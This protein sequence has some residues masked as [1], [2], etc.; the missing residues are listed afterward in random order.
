MNVTYAPS[1]GRPAPT[2]DFVNMVRGELFKISRNTGIWVT[3]GILTV[4]FLTFQAGSI[5]QV[6]ALSTVSNTFSSNAT[7]NGNPFQVN[8]A[9]YLLQTV[10]GTVN[11]WV[12]IYLMAVAVIVVALEYQQGTIRVLL[13]RGVGRMRLLSAKVSAVILYGLTALLLALALTVGEV[14]SMFNLSNHGD[15]IANL[16]DYFWSD[17]ATYVLT[18]L[19]GMLATISLAATFAVL[20]RSLAFGL[21]FTLPYFL[22]ENIVG[23]IM[24]GIGI[25]TQS[26]WLY[27][28]TQFFL[29]VNINNIPSKLLSGHSTI[30]SL[31]VNN[32]TTNNP[33]ILIHDAS[34]S[35]IVVV[36]YIVGLGAIA[37]TV[38][39]YRDVQN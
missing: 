10:L 21:G 16:P 19:L 12:G 3:S 31:N 34:F 4:F 18:I 26:Y 9:E 33:D 1:D 17:S 15:L 14:Y 13:S 20:G 5:I 29:G 36:T 6:I 22:V 38:T 39:R 32:F 27:N 7:V 11:G 30:N 24:K 25:S 35:I 23:V 37:Y 2:P 28:I 8:T